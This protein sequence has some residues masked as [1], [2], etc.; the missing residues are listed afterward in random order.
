MQGP[1]H[2]VADL[3]GPTAGDWELRHGLT[4]GTKYRVAVAFSDADEYA[5]AVGEMWVFVGASFSKFEDEI[6][7]FVCRTDKTYW[8]IPLSWAR[9][10]QASVIENIERHLAISS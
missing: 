9:Q 6:T 4:R 7:I 5:H 8:K 3:H 2:S 1:Y 10:R